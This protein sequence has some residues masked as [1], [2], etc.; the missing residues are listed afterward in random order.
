MILY[1]FLE[2]ANHNKNNQQILDFCSYILKKHYQKLDD[3]YINSI[4]NLKLDF[5]PPER[6][7]IVTTTENLLNISLRLREKFK[8][9]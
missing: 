6:R 7:N 2:D 4:L 9:I 5:S 3:D 8:K 1:I